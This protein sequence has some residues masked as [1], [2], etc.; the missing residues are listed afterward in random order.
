MRTLQRDDRHPTIGRGAVRIR[1]P[2]G[3]ELA[4][5]ARGDDGTYELAP[6]PAP[7]FSAVLTRV[8]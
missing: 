5:A 6:R 3:W 1:P 4:G 2:Q 8:P 7:V